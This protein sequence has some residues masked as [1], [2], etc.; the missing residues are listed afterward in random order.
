MNVI[1][2][3]AG[4]FVGKNLM[5]HFEKQSGIHASSLS[6]RQGFTKEDVV[7]A[8]VI[9]HLAGKAHDLKKTSD[10]AE[11]F[12]VNTDLTKKLFDL[13]LESDVK[14]FIYF[15]SVKAVA[16]EVN[17][18]LTEDVLP[19]PLTVY[20][21]SKRLAEEYILSKDLPKGKRLFI[22]R[23][24]MIHGPGNKG[25]LNLLYKVV[26]KGIPYPLAAY[27]NQRSFL[28]IDN[29]IYVV[30][31]VILNPNIEGGIYNLSDDKSLSTN[32]VIKLISDVLSQKPKL[33]AINKKVIHSVA[34]VGDWLKLPLNSERLQKLT[35]SYVVANKKIR[36]ALNIDALPI[37]AKEGL[38]NTIRSF[39]GR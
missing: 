26:E 31:R 15:S 37:S 3:G 11:Y 19:A 18:E 32:E 6:L 9:I 25:N 10:D 38:T 5:Q 22:F 4:G 2:T 36:K 17:G 39:T 35:E 13:F 21:K 20:G 27:Q 33:W 29:L 8:D 34:K 7:K 16:D 1:V 12:K 30:E 23:P 14:D 24:C 28:A